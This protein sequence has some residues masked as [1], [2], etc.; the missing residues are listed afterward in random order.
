MIR[1]N[2]Y[3]SAISLAV[4]AVLAGSPQMAPAQTEAVV[5]EEIV[6]TA[7]KRVESIQD[8]P[9]AVSAMSGENMEKLNI[10]S[11]QDIGPLAPNLDVTHNVG[12]QNF[13]IRGIGTGVSFPGFE[14]AVATYIDGAYVARP[15][16]AMMHLPNIE[17]IEILRGPQG[18]L[19]GR[20][21]TGGLIN[22]TTKGPTED[23]DGSVSLSYGNYDT[24]EGKFF[25]SGAFSDRV[26]ASLSVAGQ[27]QG[28]GF[29]TNRVSGKDIVHEDYLSV[30]GRLVFKATDNFEIELA[31]YY[32]ELDS[33][34]AAVN[35]VPKGARPATANGGLFFD[36]TPA[37]PANFTTKP[38]D[39]Y[40]NAEPIYRFEETGASLTMTYE[41]D[42]FELVSI[43]NYNEAD[44]LIGG[45]ID[46]TDALGWAIAFVPGGVNGTNP[47]VN[48]AASY[49]FPDFL[50]QEIRLTSTGD[51]PLQWVA[52]AYYQDST[53]AYDPIGVYLTSH[54]P[55]WSHQG[56]I[57]LAAYAQSI[58]GSVTLEAL[59]IYAQLNY[60]VT[61][62]LN[63]TVGARH[64]DEEK[65]HYGEVY[66]NTSWPTGA[67]PVRVIRI[68]NDDSWT[69]PTWHLAASYEFDNAMVYAS[70]NTGFKSGA[71]NVSSPSA[72][73]PVEE[74][75]VDS[76]E[77]GFKSDLMNGR[78]RL[79]GN[80]FYWQTDDMQ[81][82]VLSEV[83]GTAI[84]QNAAE[85]EAKGLELELTYLPT[86]GMTLFANLGWIDSEYTSF[87]NYVGRPPQVDEN[88]NPIG[89]T[90]VTPLDVEGE[91]VIKSPEHTISVGMFYERPVGDGMT[92]EFNLDVTH[93]GEAYNDIEHTDTLKQDSYALA[94]AS[95]GLRIPRND[96]VYKITAWGRNLADETVLVGGG[97]VFNTQRARYNSPRT[98]GV[99]FSADF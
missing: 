94:N 49:D 70:Y 47:T 54:Q 76:Y 63:L 53:D 41:H 84:L 62:R 93:K 86:D 30:R 24:W 26:L 75:L 81:F 21:A 61:D 50:S 88:G 19:F 5:L 89:G 87:P 4:L 27:E 3:L 10:S 68:D 92:L 44:A 8:V 20:N 83:T 6:V 14:N 39:A 31:P 34:N 7:R 72:P 71:Y 29:G 97:S 46:T 23:F 12:T 35:G 98:Y 25:V 45:D 91:P 78:L 9:I 73:G 57:D 82:G 13:F 18:T 28:E 36:L 59:G 32:N 37:P 74:E 52:G 64:N 43:T 65:D 17:R 2:F 90:A 22:I 85:A 48:F 66:V 60:E 99:R 1:H 95:I 15:V 80:V 69:T 56:D 67:T 51:G 11:I 33:S 79:N 96:K 16:A 38:R 40:Y 58:V 55:R 77:F 42:N